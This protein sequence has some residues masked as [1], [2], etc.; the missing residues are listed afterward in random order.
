MIKSCKVCKEPL[1]SISID[2]HGTKDKKKHTLIYSM[3]DKRNFIT[4]LE[5]PKAHGYI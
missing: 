2:E 5:E 4:I 1:I 3:F